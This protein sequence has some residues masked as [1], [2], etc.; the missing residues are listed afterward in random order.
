VAGF[1][2][3]KDKWLEKIVGQDKNMKQAACMISLV[4][5]V[6]SV[7]SFAEEKVTDTL[8]VRIVPTRTNDKGERSITL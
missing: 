7:S 4:L 8:A 3:A 5:A 6:L 2:H 1:G